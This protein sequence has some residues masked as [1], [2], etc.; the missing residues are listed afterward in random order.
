MILQQDNVREY[1]S[2]KHETWFRIQNLIAA[3]PDCRMFV[4]PTTLKGIGK[5]YS[6]WDKMC[7]DYNKKGL[8]GIYVRW[9][10]K[11]LNA[12]LLNLKEKSAELVDKLNCE[13]EWLTS[14]EITILSNKETGEGIF[15][16][17]TPS[18][19]EALKGLTINGNLPLLNV[20]WEEFLLP[21]GI[22]LKPAE[23]LDAF[24]QLLGSMFRNQDFYVFLAANNTNPN[25]PF[26]WYMFN[27]MGWP[28]YGTTIV[29]HDAGVV[30][31]SP[32]YNGYMEKKYEASTLWKLSKMN[33]AVHKQL[34]G[35]GQLNDSLYDN[36]NLIIFRMRKPVNFKFNMR[37]GVT[38]FYFYTYF[39][40]GKWLMYVSTANNPKVTGIMFAGT[41]VT[42]LET[43]LKLIEEHLIRSIKGYMDE[44]KVRYRDVRTMGVII[45]WIENYRDDNEII[46]WTKKEEK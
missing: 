39:D 34:F 16:F 18:G 36:Q 9:K 38:I 27:N 22:Y 19:F 15:Y 4:V 8:G 14:G 46:D 23:T 3:Y 25:N 30:I 6:I 17:I 1:K 7:D 13:T 20:F 44:N 11:E 32:E 10:K 33:P 42:A 31:D 29:D 43:G 5:S 12:I 45:E 41:R 40:N 21:Q 35:K 24:W 2:I 28:E 37:I 26:L